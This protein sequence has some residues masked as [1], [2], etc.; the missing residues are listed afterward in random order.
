MNWTRPRTHPWR[1]LDIHSGAYNEQIWQ[2]NNWTWVQER[3]QPGEWGPKW[4][5]THEQQPG[6]GTK[7][8]KPRGCNCATSHTFY[9]FDKHCCVTQN[10][11]SFSFHS[12][13]IPVTNCDVFFFFGRLQPVSHPKQPT[14][15]RHVSSLSTQDVRSSRKTQT[16]MGS[17]DHIRMRYELPILILQPPL[18]APPLVTARESLTTHHHHCCEHLLAG[19]VGGS[20]DGD[21]GRT[22][23]GRQMTRRNEW[24]QERVDKGDASIMGREQWARQRRQGWP[25]RMKPT[26]RTV[27]REVTFPFLISLPPLPHWAGGAVLVVMYYC[28]FPCVRTRK[29][30][31]NIFS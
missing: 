16:T 15:T 10:T 3:Q 28:C 19:W 25:N 7:N 23:T 9:A 4:V 2:A 1:S 29:G 31:L 14:N 12:S 13:L 20:R 5:G 8:G 11:I 30:Q 6:G 17:R 21:N 26:G 24:Q 27:V 22:G 18:T